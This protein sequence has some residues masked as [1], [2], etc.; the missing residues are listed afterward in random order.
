MKVLFRKACLGQK[1]TPCVG[2]VEEIKENNAIYPHF[3]A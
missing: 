3:T 2:I 1:Q